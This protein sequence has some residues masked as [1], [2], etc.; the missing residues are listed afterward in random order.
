MRI[1]FV[2]CEHPL[3]VRIK[4]EA[5]SLAKAGHQVF[6]L[7][8]E[9]PTNQPVTEADAITVHYYPPLQ[10]NGFRDAITFFRR[11][12]FLSIPIEPLVEDF[13]RKYEIDVLHVHDLPNV[14]TGIRVGK[15]LGIP[16]VA[17][18]HEN[19]PAAVRAWIG[20]P[21]PS[22]LISTNQTIWHSYQSRCVY[23]ADKVITVIEEGRDV[24]LGYGI[25]PY[26]VYVVPNYVDLG[27]L[28]AYAGSLEPVTGYEGRFVVSYI[29]FVG[30]DRGVDIAVKAM[31][32]VS[33]YAPDVLL[34]VVGDAGDHPTYFQQVK[35]MVDPMGI[36]R[37]VELTGWQP[38]EKIPGYVA[39][40]AVGLVPHQRNPHR[41]NTI[42]N[43]L[44]D[45]MGFGKPVIVSDCP[46]LKRIVD[47]SESGLVFRADDPEELAEC[48]LTLYNDNALA[49]R[50]G[51][52]G[53][54]AVRT[55]Y[56]WTEAE[57]ELLRL[58][59]TFAGKD[60]TEVK[61]RAPHK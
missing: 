12:S 45:Y 32:K 34:L 57:A 10:S 5:R 42:P 56:N 38:F 55:K 31:S 25:D 46:P 60:A 43:K 9:R 61:S 35:Q 50:L 20:R 3:D 6:A 51:R 4:K 37:S 22:Q 16:V 52:N 19:H 21:R 13:A 29:G 48:I 54:S 17:D 40:T 23:R 36:Q 53:E 27:Y 44:F 18:L 47:E 8:Q 14:G 1:G 30:P 49:T 26:K 58:Y 2:L 15:K 7:L 33:Q 11:M 59:T 28:E 39:A 24:M 41:D